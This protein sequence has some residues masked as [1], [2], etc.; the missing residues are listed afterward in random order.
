MAQVIG[1]KFFMQAG[2]DIT[3]GGRLEQAQYQYTLTD[4][5]SDELNHWAPICP[6]PNAVDEDPDRCRVRPADR[7]AAHCRSQ[8]D[9]DAA[10]RL[11]ISLTAIDTSLY[12]AFG[13][14]QIA[15]IYLPTQQAKVILEVQP[16]YQTGPRPVEYLCRGQQRPS[17]AVGGGALCQRSGAADDQSSGRF[18]AVTLSFNLAPGVALSQAVDAISALKPNCARRLRCTA[19][20]KGR[21]RHSSPR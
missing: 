21:R 4:T 1:A 5:N 17:A 12:T 19:V 2:Q 15:T 10:S 3:I 13:Q 9:R 7:L 14:Q 11:G 8:V 16:K 20:S 18:S 6:R